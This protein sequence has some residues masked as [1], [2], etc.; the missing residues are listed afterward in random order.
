M[1]R[2]SANSRRLGTTKHCS[3]S[4]MID[5][6]AC[7]ALEQYVCSIDADLKLTVAGVDVLA[8]Q[9]G[10]QGNGAGDAFIEWGTKQADELGCQVSMSMSRFSWAFWTF[11][12]RARR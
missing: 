5:S 7:S 1:F 8:I 12:K 2:E 10:R 9:P 6:L 11:S 4:D 3:V